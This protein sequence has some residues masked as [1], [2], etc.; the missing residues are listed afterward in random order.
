MIINT[1]KKLILLVFAAFLLVRCDHFEELNQNPVTSTDMD[2]NLM[3]PT[4]QLQLSG[5]QFEQLRNGF[6]YS[7]EWMQHWTGEYASTEYGGKGVRND[8]YMGALWTAQYPREVKNI[9]DMVER[10]TGVPENVNINA[11]SRIM[12]V[13]IFSRL[14]DLYGDI[15]YFDAGKGY[16]TRLF[17]PKFDRQEDIYNH[18]F[19]ELDG[20]VKSFDASQKAIT[21][22]FYFEGNIEQWKRFANSLRLRL[23]M[24]LTKVNIEKAEQQAEA[25]IAL[26]TMQSNDDMAVMQHIVTTWRGGTFGGNGVSYTFMN[27]STTA[28]ESLFRM[29]STFASYMEDMNDPRITMYGRSYLKSEN[30]PDD[31][32]DEVF[33]VVGSYTQMS[34]LPSTFS[35]EASSQGAAIDVEYN[36]NTVKDLTKLYQCL[37]PSNYIARIDAPYI[38]MSYAEV[39]LWKAEAAFRGWDTGASVQEHFSKALEAGVKQMYTYGVPEVDESVVSDFVDANPIVSGQELEQINNQLWVNFALNGQ[40]AWA[41]WRRSGF[42]AIEYPNRDPGVNQSGGEIPRRMQY[43]QE[44]LDYNTANAQEAIARMPGATDSWMNRVW[45]DK[46]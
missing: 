24:R 15:P 40:E 33:D 32:T 29:C 11:V 46:E 14:T 5:G 31:I 45:W 16:Y 12:K 18:F 19:E 7:G 10:T 9:V 27:T 41:N 36:G 13:Y 2:P 22:D 1:H 20:A 39:E 37:Q 44:E 43:P 17:T 26:G 6:I 34:L 30:R 4:I 23:A 38:M 8:A 42:P 25:A 21:E 28:D 3:L 35:W